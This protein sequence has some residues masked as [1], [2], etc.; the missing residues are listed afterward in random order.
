MHITSCL[1]VKFHKFSEARSLALLRRQMV[2]LIWVKAPSYVFLLVFLF[3]FCKLAPVMKLDLSV[4]F[5]L[6]VCIM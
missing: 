3:F 4:F 1:L 2:A 5:F 6:Y